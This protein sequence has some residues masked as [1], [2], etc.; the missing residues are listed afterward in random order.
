MA[1]NLFFNTNIDVHGV[2]DLVMNP[3]RAPVTT[4]S[5]GR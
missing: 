3:G 1:V 2:L 4:C 5:S